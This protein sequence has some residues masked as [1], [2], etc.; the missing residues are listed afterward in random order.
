M[1]KT[2]KLFTVNGFYRVWSGVPVKKLENCLEPG[3]CSWQWRVIIGF[4]KWNNVIGSFPSYLLNDH[5]VH[6]TTQAL[7]ESK[8]ERHILISS[9]GKTIVMKTHKTKWVIWILWQRYKPHAELYVECSWYKPQNKLRYQVIEMD[10][11][12][13][14][15]VWEWKHIRYK[16]QKLSLFGF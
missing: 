8:G 10:L 16:Q 5:N 13:Q 6:N 15:K 4:Y 2:I 12:W 7:W 14:K 1:C 11:K 9:W 3:C